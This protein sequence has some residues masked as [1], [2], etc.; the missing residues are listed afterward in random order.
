MSSANSQEQRAQDERERQ[1][2]VSMRA[3]TLRRMSSVEAAAMTEHA[4]YKCLGEFKAGTVF[5]IMKCRKV[6]GKHGDFPVVSYLTYDTETNE[7][8]DGDLALPGR[9]LDAALHRPKP[10]LAI[11][12]GTKALPGNG[13][14]KCHLFDFVR[15][16]AVQAS[17]TDDDGLHTCIDCGNRWD[18][19]N[20]CLC[21]M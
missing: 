15:E 9:Y 12:S 7:R 4:P 10:C 1:R 16:D 8:S 20:Q 14:R 13:G 6:T 3:A 5:E 17:F 19:N 11:Y 18:G 2:L 21:M